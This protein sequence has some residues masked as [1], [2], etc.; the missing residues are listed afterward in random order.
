[1]GSY[2]GLL[3]LV[4]G[5]RIQISAYIVK[6]PLNAIKMLGVEHKQL[7]S[8]HSHFG[9]LV[10]ILPAARLADGL[11]EAVNGFVVQFPQRHPLV[12]GLLVN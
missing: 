11:T 5:N 8:G 4:G 9:Y 2:L 10:S 12:E 1:M 7:K 3:G 6:L